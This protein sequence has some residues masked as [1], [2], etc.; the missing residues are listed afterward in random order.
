MTKLEELQR[1]LKKAEGEYEF[2]QRMAE[3]IQTTLWTVLK[4]RLTA[5]INAMAIEEENEND[6]NR[7]QRLV[8]A[9]R[10]LRVFRDDIDASWDLEKWRKR[11][12]KI[13]DELAMEAK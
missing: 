1:R 12:N 2:R 6:L 8:G 3:M 9:R 7:M 10:A 11:L 4:T 5:M 13:K